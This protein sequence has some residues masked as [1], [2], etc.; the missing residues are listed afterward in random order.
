MRRVTVPTTRY[1]IDA[2]YQ[3]RFNDGREGYLSETDVIAQTVSDHIRKKLSAEKAACD[4]AGGVSVGMS[5]KQ[6]LASCWGKPRHI[7]QTVTA[8]GTDEQ[9]VYRS[10]YIYLRNGVVVG[11]QT[12]R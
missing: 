1:V 4:K 2:Y 7:N 5:R 9:L 10:G 3:V 12:R 6:V 8:N 11:I